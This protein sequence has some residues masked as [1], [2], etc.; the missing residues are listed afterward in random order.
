MIP[1]VSASMTRTSGPG[2][3]LADPQKP[4]RPRPDRGTVFA[5]CCGFSGPRSTRSPADTF[6]GLQVVSS[7]LRARPS[8]Q[9]GGF[10]RCHR[11]RVADHGSK[12]KMKPAAALETRIPL[13]PD[14]SVST[15]VLNIIYSSSSSKKNEAKKP[16]S[17]SS[18]KKKEAKEPYELSHHFKTVKPI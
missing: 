3:L 8:S 11:S 12:K 1:R 5:P 17:S 7:G 6:A 4:G 2:G 15:R 16:Y 14:P 9:R 13:V 18:S 10:A